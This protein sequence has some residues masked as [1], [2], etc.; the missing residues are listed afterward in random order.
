M[1]TLLVMKFGMYFHLHK[2]LIL[3]FPSM[4]KLGKEKAT[5]YSDMAS[6]SQDVIRIWLF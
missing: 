4:M 1:P 3:A 2:D 6:M 5:C